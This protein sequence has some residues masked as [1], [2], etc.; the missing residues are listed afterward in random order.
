MG[1]PSIRLTWT[2]DVI[3]AMPLAARPCRN[4]MVPFSD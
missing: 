3:G 4:D 2:A 1:R